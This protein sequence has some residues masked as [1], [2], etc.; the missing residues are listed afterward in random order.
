MDSIYAVADTNIGRIGL[1]FCQEGDYPEP[2]RGLA[3][4][5][6]EIIYRC[7]YAE[8]W[9]G[10]GAWEIQNRARALDN[11]CYVVAPNIGPCRLMP[12]ELAPIDVS[13]G[14]SMVID[15]RGQILGYH[16]PTT[17]SYT[18]GVIDIGA[19]RH[20]RQKAGIGGWL[21]ELKSEI[22]SLIYQ[23]PVYPRNLYNESPDK[24]HA[25]RHTAYQDSR[26]ELIRRGIWSK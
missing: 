20:Y 26:D 15:Y 19:L 3:M 22:Y 14:K 4:N 21:K 1:I 10:R 2:A 8:P 16:G 7:S 11:T 18:S 24:H 9:V 13:G 23:E 12:N 6:A 25:D 5:G 17:N